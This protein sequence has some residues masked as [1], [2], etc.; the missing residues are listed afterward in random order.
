[1]R[2]I[3][4]REDLHLLMSEFY[5]KLLADSKIAPVFIKVAK[6]DLGPH[7]LELVDFW[8]QILFDTGS[9]RKNVLQIHTDLNQKI[10]LSEEHFAIWLNYFNTT[11]DENFVGVIA[12][13]MKTRALSIATVMK[14]KL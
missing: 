5:L 9:Y 6:I 10:K 13:N 12:E 4:T 11:I 7:L 3:Q 1:M 2:D 14:I 8:Q